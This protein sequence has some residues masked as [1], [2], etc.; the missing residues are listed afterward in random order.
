MQHR[1]RIPWHL[2]ALFCPL[3]HLW[4][5]FFSENAHAFV[6][7]MSGRAAQRAAPIR[8]EELVHSPAVGRPRG[9]E[10]VRCTVPFDVSSR[11]PREPS[12]TMPYS[13]NCQKSPRG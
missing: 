6:G 9:A 10:L 13:D 1:A 11:Y 12:E 4:S 8:A 7:A 2:G 3:N 5:S